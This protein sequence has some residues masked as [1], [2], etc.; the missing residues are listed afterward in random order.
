MFMLFLQE[1]FIILRIFVLEEKTPVLVIIMINSIKT[2][3][4]LHN[5]CRFRLKLLT[6]AMWSVITRTWT[7]VGSFVDVLT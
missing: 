4:P 1:H 6:K 5:L 2:Y 7:S 3:M